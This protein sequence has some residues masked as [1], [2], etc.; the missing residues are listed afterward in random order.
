MCAKRE[1]RHLAAAGQPGWGQD[2][3]GSAGPWGAPS[4]ERRSAPHD[5]LR[6]IYG[7]LPVPLVCLAADRTVPRGATLA[8]PLLAEVGVGLNWDQAH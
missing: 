3:P 8:V 1:A 7:S 6:S 4:L 5:A 2:S